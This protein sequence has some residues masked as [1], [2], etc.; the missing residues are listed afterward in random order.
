M[1]SGG[2]R[3]YLICL[4]LETKFGDNLSYAHWQKTTLTLNLDKIHFLWSQIMIREITKKNS[5]PIFKSRNLPNCRSQ[6]GY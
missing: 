5:K 2:D 1:I 3:R 4:I 6:V